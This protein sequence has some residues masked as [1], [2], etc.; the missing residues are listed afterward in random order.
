MVVKIHLFVFS[1]RFFLGNGSIW[2]IVVRLVETTRIDWGQQRVVCWFE[3]N[4]QVHILCASLCC[5]NARRLSILDM[6]KWQATPKAP[7]LFAVSHGCFYARD[8]GT[9]DLDIP[10]WMIENRS[11]ISKCES[12]REQ[13]MT[14]LFFFLVPSWIFWMDHVNFKGFWRGF[15]T[16]QGPWRKTN[17]LIYWWWMMIFQANDVCQK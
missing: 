14:C 1:P 15:A 9:M 6:D 7:V 11:Q 2:R 13:V 17:R 12:T 4:Q 10:S 16:N 5:A 8:K 3:E